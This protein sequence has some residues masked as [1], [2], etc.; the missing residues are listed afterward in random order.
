MRGHDGVSRHL[1]LVGVPWYLGTPL[2][3][4]GIDDVNGCTGLLLGMLGVGDCITDD[5]LKEHFED[6]RSLLVDQARDTLDTTS[7]GQTP[8][9]GLG[10]SLDVITEHLPVTLGAS[11]SKT[12][13]SFTTSRHFDSLSSSY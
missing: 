10:D 11:L 12:L 2:S 6:S 5:V 4:N 1:R 9:G 8:D 3:I 7:A 13:A